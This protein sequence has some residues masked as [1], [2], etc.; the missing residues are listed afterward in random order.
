[1]EP[2]SQD[3]YHILGVSNRASQEEIKK[4]YRSLAKKY[5]PDANPGDNV[6]EQKFKAVNDAYAVL[7]DEKKRLE[8]DQSKQQTHTGPGDRSSKA[9][10]GDK[11]GFRDK[12]TMDPFFQTSKT[13]ADF[14]GFDKMQNAKKS[15]E[16]AEHIQNVNRKF[17][18]F[19]GFTPNK[20]K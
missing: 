5:H 20:K 19:F 18:D 11:G 8:Y 16:G 4:A 1:M 6:A 14:M 9:S 2:T 3:L 7:G 13:F 10:T 17:E 15:K 12:R